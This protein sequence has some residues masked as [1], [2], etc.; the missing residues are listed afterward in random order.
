MTTDSCQ[1]L[2]L[3]TEFDLQRLPMI[4]GHMLRWGMKSKP[5][6]GKEWRTPFQKPPHTRPTWSKIRAAV[7]LRAVRD[8]IDPT[9]QVKSSLFEEKEISGR[10]RGNTPPMVAS[11]KQL[12]AN[13]QHHW[14]RKGL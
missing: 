8:G 6:P 11:F 1:S 10:I 4:A 9:N 14:D 5:K 3:R 2:P 7:G 12:T 13:R